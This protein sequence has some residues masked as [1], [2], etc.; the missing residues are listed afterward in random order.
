MQ[1]VSIV[2][3]GEEGTSDRRIDGLAKFFGLHTTVI[4]LSNVAN[5]DVGRRSTGCLIV[6]AQSLT[7]I[8]ADPAIS[9]T[10][11]GELFDRTPFV[12][13]YGIT[14]DETHTAAVNSVTNG[15]VSTVIPFEGSNHTYQVSS[16][17]RSVTAEFTGLTFGPINVQSDHA[18][19]VKIARPDFSSIVAINGHAFFARQQRNS[20]SLFLLGCSEIADLNAA[21]DGTL[22]ARKYFSHLVPIM[23]FLRHVFPNHTWHNPREQPLRPRQH[24]HD[25]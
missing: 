4:D 17:H 14:G 19:V 10:F 23:M 1:D 15:L 22:T 7:A 5:A 9:R 11:V 24:Q 6:S 3:Y 8:L 18:M 12:L 2:V 13:L 25:Q 21:T 20:S 16:V